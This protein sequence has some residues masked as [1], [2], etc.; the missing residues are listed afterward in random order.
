MLDGLV[1]AVRA[2]ESRTLVLHGE[3]GIGKT[4][5]LNYVV[6]SA[7][8]M[9]LL[10]AVGAESEMELAFASL[11]Q[12]CAPLLEAVERLPPPQRHALEVAFGLS[13]GPAPDRFLVGLALL[14]LLSEAAEERPLLCVV[15]DAQ[16]LDEVSARTLAFV[17]RRLLAEP[18]GLLF[19]SRVAAPDLEGF[20]ELEILGLSE[21]RRTCASGFGRPVSAR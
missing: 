18:V 6:E 20:P 21:R 8:D 15:D 10:R 9:R 19:A 11:H 14:T 3:A 16:W 1:A 4:A 2:G 17:A 5:L 12:L 7:A 13:E